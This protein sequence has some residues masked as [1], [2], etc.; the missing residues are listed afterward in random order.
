MKKGFQNFYTNGILQVAIECRPLLRFAFLIQ[1]L[2]I[3]RGKHGAL[4]AR[5][6]AIRG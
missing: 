2:E 4:L 6:P 5:Q 1:T 3:M